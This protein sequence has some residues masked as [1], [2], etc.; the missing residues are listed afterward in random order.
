MCAATD[1]VH[2]IREKVTRVRSICAQP[3]ILKVYSYSCRYCKKPSS[4]NKS[5]FYSVLSPHILNQMSLRLRATVPYIPVSSRTF[6]TQ[7]Q[8]DHLVFMLEL[9]LSHAAVAKV[10]LEAQSMAMARAEEKR[11]DFIS[12]MLD[13]HDKFVASPSVFSLVRPNRLVL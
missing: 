10:G 4:G 13:A 1:D 11:F 5:S 8:L 3:S 2:D 6:M 7:S 9:G 12:P